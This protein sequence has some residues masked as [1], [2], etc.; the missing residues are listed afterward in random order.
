MA[1]ELGTAVDRAEKY[2][3]SGITR[4][5]VRRFG[6]LPMN[7]G[8]MGM[9]PMHAHDIARD[10][11]DNG[12]SENRY[13]AVK[14]VRLNAFWQGIVRADNQKMCEGNP[15]MPSYSPIMDHGCLKLTHFSFSEKLFQDGNRFLY[16]HAQGRMIKKRSDDA[17]GQEMEREG[18]WCIIYDEGLLDDA[19][20]VEA[21]MREDNMN[22]S[23]SMDEDVM[24]AYGC[25]DHVMRS[26]SEPRQEADPSTSQARSQATL[27]SED[28]IKQAKF[29]LTDPKYNREYLTCLI[30]FRARLKPQQS[31]VFCWAIE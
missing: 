18:P 12:T 10:R 29:L 7:R 17:E 14:L 30:N 4:M 1:T 5:P 31:E 11:M 15:L 13:G 19:L 26:L 22:A 28:I 27:T 6:F 24:S 25:L 3:R 9:S 16:N 23:V 21:L 8:G 2:R 20:A